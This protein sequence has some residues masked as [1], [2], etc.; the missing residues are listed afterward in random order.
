MN[1]PKTKLHALVDSMTD[2]EAERALEVLLDAPIPGVMSEDDPGF[3]DEI[4]RRSQAF[5]NGEPGIPLDVALRRGRERLKRA[6][7]STSTT[8]PTRK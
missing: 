5:R 1:A 3:W 6:R 4:Q 8:R 7:S 2:E